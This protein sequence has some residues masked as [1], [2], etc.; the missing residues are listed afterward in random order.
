MS[1]FYDTTS[2]EICNIVLCGFQY[3]ILREP[4]KRFVVPPSTVN[5]NQM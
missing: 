4:K 3:T 2:Q 1:L 5:R